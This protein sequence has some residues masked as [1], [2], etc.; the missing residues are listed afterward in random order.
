LS[1]AAIELKQG[2][3]KGYQ[4]AIMRGGSPR[5]KDSL[6]ENLDFMLEIIGNPKDPLMQ[7]IKDI[8]DALL[9]PDF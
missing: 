2:V 5:E 4:R 7:A 9:R 1:I 6:I 3:I 8:R